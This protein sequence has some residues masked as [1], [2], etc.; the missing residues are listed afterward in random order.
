MKV[1]PAAVFSEALIEAG[2]W[3]EVAEGAGLFGVFLE[4]EGGA[5]E[6]QLR[7]LSDVIA[8]GFTSD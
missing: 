7:S 5:A 6:Q 8:S 3:E 4:A 1:P 2:S